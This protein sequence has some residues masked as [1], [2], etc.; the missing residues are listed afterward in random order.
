[1]TSHH[2]RCTKRSWGILALGLLLSSL[3]LSSQAA[4]EVP[5]LIR[6]QGQAADANGVPLEG[7]Y[8][9]T[10]RLYD[11]D[12]AGTKVWEERQDNVPLTGGHFSVLLGSRTSLAAL[13]WA[14]PCWLSVQVNGESELAPRQRITSVPLAVRSRT[15]EQLAVPITTSTIVD[16]SSRLVPSGAI[17]LWDG[18]SCPAGYTRLSSHDGKFL[19]ASSASGATGGS[20][21]HSHGGATGSH[22]LTVA[23]IPAHLHTGVQI[24]V[25]GGGDRY[26]NGE[27]HYGND[28]AV[29]TDNT[30]GGQG[31][32]HTIAAADSRPEFKTILLCKKD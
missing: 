16:D 6:Y 28:R 14:A 3:L 27:W 18:A 22:A 24:P 32:S 23:E 2:S 11:A 5:A 21:S 10:F 13:D 25:G 1:M 15:A 31:H 9:L 29:S 26:G 4:A 20:N 19:V 7:P 12:T 8:T 17:I 30:G